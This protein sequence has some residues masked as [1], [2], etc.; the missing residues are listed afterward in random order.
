MSHHES[1]E[2]WDEIE[3]SSSELT[4]AAL[5]FFF[6]F[7]YST[8]RQDPHMCAAEEGMFSAFSKLLKANFQPHLVIHSEGL[9]PD[10]NNTS[11]VLLVS[12]FV[13]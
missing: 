11:C 7:L 12:E 4:T 13:M 3:L 5:S 9:N 1:E 8:G 10:C 2:L 6:A